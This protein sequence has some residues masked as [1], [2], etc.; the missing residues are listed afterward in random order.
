MRYKYRLPTHQ[1]NIIYYFMFC[2]LS[3]S[4]WSSKEKPIWCTIYSHYISST[5]TYFGRIYGPSSGCTTICIQKLVL[6]IFFRWLSVVLVGVPTSTTDSHLKRN[7]KYQVFYTYVCT[8]WWWAINAPETCRGWRNIMRI[9]CA[10][11]WFFF[12]P[13]Y[14]T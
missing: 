7:N 5:S 3:I 4:I 14:I 10:S 6:I 2:W 12:A 9:N 1:P 13:S 11:N 8:S